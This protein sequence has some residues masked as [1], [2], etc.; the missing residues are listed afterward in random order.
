ML[1]ALL[2]APPE[3][4]KGTQG[5]RL[6]RNDDTPGTIRHRLEVYSGSTRPYSS[7][8]GGAGYIL[9]V[10]GTGSVEEVTERARRHLAQ[11]DLS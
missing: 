9:N 2:L 6:R 1:R 11:L 5:D 10:D 3:T 8:I 7:S 4:S